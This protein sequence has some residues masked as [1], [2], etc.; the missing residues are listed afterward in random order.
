[1]APQTGRYENIATEA[2]AL[3]ESLYRYRSFIDGNK[4]TATTVGE[5][6]LNQ[7]GYRIAVNDD[8]DAY[9]FFM[10]LFDEGAFTF[11]NLVP[12]LEEYVKPLS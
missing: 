8:F 7:N 1:M 11:V 2:A 4:R 10:D 6:F 3:M 9:D 12:W 5:V